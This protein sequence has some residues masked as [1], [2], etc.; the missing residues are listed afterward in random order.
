MAKDPGVEEPQPH[1][2]RQ[3]LEAVAQHAKDKRGAA[4]KLRLAQGA[5]EQMAAVDRKAAQLVRTHNEVNR[6]AV[7]RGGVPDLPYLEE[8]VDSMRTKHSPLG[9]K[10]ARQQ[11]KMVQ[12]LMRETE[13]RNTGSLTDLIIKACNC[14]KVK[15]KP[16]S[17]WFVLSGLSDATEYILYKSKAKDILGNAVDYGFVIVCHDKPPADGNRDNGI[18]SVMQRGEYLEAMLIYT[19]LEL[20]L[21]FELASELLVRLQKR[22]REER[23]DMASCKHGQLL[24]SLMNLEDD[25]AAFAEANGTCK[26]LKCGEG[27][28]SFELK[29]PIA[30]TPEP[31]ISRVL[32]IAECLQGLLKSISQA[33]KPTTA[34]AQSEADGKSEAQVKSESDVGSKECTKSETH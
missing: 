19:C 10:G 7:E 1:Y 9:G 16:A 24:E 2:S 30:D 21:N 5:R 13:V 11:R 28:T 23:I 25:L 26:A 18:L 22:E 14:S 3:E 27:M 15:R 17:Q 32:H 4:A 12:E 8:M 6:L 34:S 20:L 29:G 33:L 31:L